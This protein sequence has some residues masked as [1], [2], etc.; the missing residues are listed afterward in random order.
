[1]RQQGPIGLT[2]RIQS[3]LFQSLWSTSEAPEVE[4]LKRFRA[5]KPSPYKIAEE[6]ESG[7]RRILHSARVSDGVRF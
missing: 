3:I 1:M 4:R 2:A 5:F 6:K 7:P